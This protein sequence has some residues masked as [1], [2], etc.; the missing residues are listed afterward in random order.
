M[1]IGV[2]G[3][4]IVGQ[5]LAKGLK[6][7]GHEVKIASREGNKLAAFREETAIA[8]GRFSDVTSFAEVVVL[9]VKGDVAES[10]V[11][12]LAPALSGKVVLDTCNPIAGAPE[13]GMIPYFTAGNESLIER[14]QKAAPDAKFVKWFN[15]VGAHLMVAP[16]LQ[17]GT[18]T[19]FICGD[20]AQ[21]KIVASQLARDLRWNVEDVGPARLGHAVEALCQLWCAPGFLRNDW[22]H[23]FAVLRP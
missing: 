18:P 7:L 2:L 16:K 14:L 8:E 15:S 4:G 17:G 13:A 12:E 5:T 21:A 11:K 20:D 10:L 9:A 19:M 23:A 1:K 3:S 6:A 22:A